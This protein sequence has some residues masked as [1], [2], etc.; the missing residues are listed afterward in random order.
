MGTGRGLMTRGPEGAPLRV[1]FTDPSDLDFRFPWWAGPTG[2]KRGLPGRRFTVG[3]AEMSCTVACA[4]SPGRSRILNSLVYMILQFWLIPL[5]LDMSDKRFAS[6]LKK[7]T[8]FS[9][10]GLVVS[11]PVPDD[12]AITLER[13][14]DPGGRPRLPP[15]LGRGRWRPGIRG[16]NRPTP[17]LPKL[18]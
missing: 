15:R 12:E 6:G 11:R 10:A 16:V 2:L 18:G 1:F 8:S 4:S 9:N 5:L 14:P 13:L 7:P 3:L 17:K